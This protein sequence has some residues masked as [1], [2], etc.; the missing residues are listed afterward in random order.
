MSDEFE[1]DTLSLEDIEE[2]DYDEL[3]GPGDENWS[4]SLDDL[5]AEDWDE[6]YGDEEE[7]LDG[8]PWDLN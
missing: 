5:D 2:D 1:E 3:D 4:D 6:L 7:E 8:D